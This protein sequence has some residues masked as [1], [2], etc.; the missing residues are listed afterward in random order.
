[1]FFEN[2]DT[3]E[4][5]I[6]E[7]EKNKQ[8]VSLSMLE[9]KMNKL[10]ALKDSQWGKQAHKVGWKEEFPDVGNKPPRKAYPNPNNILKSPGVIK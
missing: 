3:I 10:K 1:M 6:H 9:N 7:E 4:S 5:A 2:K 8:V